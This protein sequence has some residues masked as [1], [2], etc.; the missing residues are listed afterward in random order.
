[1]SSQ[2]LSYCRKCGELIGADEDGNYC[3]ECLLEICDQDT[4]EQ[5]DNREICEICGKLDYCPQRGWK[6]YQH[7][8]SNCR[9]SIYRT[10]HNKWG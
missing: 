4:A 7:V 8:C 6:S 10:I 3:A 9:S 2:H 5:K 1:M